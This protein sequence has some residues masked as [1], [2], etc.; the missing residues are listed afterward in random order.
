MQLFAR[1]KADCFARRYR[2]FSSGSRV[3]PN[4]RFAR[5]DVEDPKTAKLY[6]VPGGQGFLQAFKDRIDRRFR[7]VAGQSR[8]FDHIVNDVLLDQRAL[9]KKQRVALFSLSRC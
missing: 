4:A 6:S 8:S 7:L 9:L 1:L 5:T 3:P 2:H